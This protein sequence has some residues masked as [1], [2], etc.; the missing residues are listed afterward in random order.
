MRRERVQSLV[1][2]GLITAVNIVLLWLSYWIFPLIYLASLPLLILT[3]RNGLRIGFLSLFVSTILLSLVISPFNAIFLALPSGLFGI[4]LG[5]GLLKKFNLKF[6]I[7]G[8]FFLLL[9]LKIV[10]IYASVILFKMPFE[11]MFG[12]EAIREGW[13]KS[14]EIANRY[15]H[16]SS[17]DDFVKIQN[18]FLENLHIFI[19]YF[20]IM[21]TLFQVFLNYM[22]VE[23][24]LKRF[25]IEAPPLPKIE[26]LRI[27]KKFFIYIFILYIILVF[28]NFPYRDYALSNLGLILQSFAL[29]NGYI[30]TWVVLKSFIHNIWL[31]W[32]FF[33]L[34]VLNPIFGSIIFIVGFIDIFFPLREKLIWVKE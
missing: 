3:C 24:V 33:L 1:E 32:I 17:E 12:I 8:G 23:K 20:L 4:F 2:G 15:F 6:L 7:I 30:F 5:Y 28:L 22:I 14:L 27:P 11:K 19:P 10:G 31:R 16:V 13:H 21:S 26:K 29:L 9:F 18:K 25:K 34:F